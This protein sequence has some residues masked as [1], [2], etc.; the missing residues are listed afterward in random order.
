MDIKSAEE[1]ALMQHAGRIVAGALATLRANVRAGITTTV[2]DRI[3]E[4][5]IRDHGAVPS[6][7]GYCG[8][9]ATICASINEEIVHG[10][11]D[12]RCLQDGDIISID[13]GAIWK[14]FH[15][16]A[17]ISIPVGS[18]P[19]DVTK[20]LEV[21]EAALAAGVAQCLPGHRLGDV[22]HAIE[23]VARASDVEVVRE[24]GGHG[25]GHEMHESPNIKNWGR[26]G[27]GL[28][29]REGMTFCLEPMFTLGGYETR[30]L[31][32]GWTVVT[33]DGSMSA[34]FEHAIAVMDGEPK[35]LTSRRD[36]ESA[37]RI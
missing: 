23:R 34:H 27:S 18:V 37:S 7:K 8:Y 2:L 16:D 31:E 17:A 29:L 30:T 36:Q 21:T 13:V 24:Y 25:I 22:S 15:G 20:L 1:I 19:E 9:P 14:G 6:F 35:V 3:G 32:D 28:Q 4:E 26:P 12:E 11:P 33:A 5:Y 10:I